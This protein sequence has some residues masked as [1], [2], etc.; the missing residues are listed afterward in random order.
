M[1]SAAV[2]VTAKALE[3][4]GSGTSHAAKYTPTDRHTLARNTGELNS[5]TAAS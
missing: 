4:R 5:S 1:A 3:K 2:S